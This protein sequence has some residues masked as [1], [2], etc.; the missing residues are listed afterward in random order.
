MA[1]PIITAERL[2]YL[3]NYDDKTGEFSWRIT[4]GGR[5][6]LGSKVGSV[7]DD[8]YVKIMIDGRS[9][10]AHQLAVLY[11]T[12]EWPPSGEVDHR[13]GNTS[14][15][16]WLNLRDA[17]HR[18]NCENRRQ[19]SSKSTTGFLGV[20]KHHRS[21]RY[22]ARIRTDGRIV[23]LGWFDTAEEAHAAYVAAKRQL[24]DGCTI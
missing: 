16:A 20:S 2:W 4:R 17:T 6:K 15:N 11:M 18:L 5:A 19:A 21:E 24:H 14:N 8:G 13:D 22:R 3:L 10:G 23:N 12:A 7:N 9:Y 1:K